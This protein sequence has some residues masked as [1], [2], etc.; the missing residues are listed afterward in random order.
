MFDLR[1]AR[2]VIGVALAATAA[3]PPADAQAPP[4]PQP[5]FDGTERR[6][7]T[8]LLDFEGDLYGQVVL[9]ELLHRLRGEQK[10]EGIDEL[11]AQISRDVEAT[12]EWFS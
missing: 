11:V 8:H 9:I 1:I 4:R 2:A 5:T 7:E 10:F 12:R 6:V 3:A